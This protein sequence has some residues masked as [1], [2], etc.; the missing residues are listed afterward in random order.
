MLAVLKL[1]I[2]DN[3]LITTEKDY[4][5]PVYISFVMGCFSLHGKTAL[6][7]GPDYVG[8]YGLDGFIKT[9]KENRV[10]E[11]YI[12]T[13]KSYKSLLHDL[14]RVVLIE[15]PEVKI[16][17]V[18][19]DRLLNSREYK[20]ARTIYDTLKEDKSSILYHLDKLDEY[21]R[22]SNRFKAIPSELKVVNESI[23]KFSKED[24]TCERKI[25]L[26]DLEYLNLID[27]VALDGDRLILNIKPL[28]IYTSEPLGRFVGYSTFQDNKYIRK[29]TEY[30]YKG[31]HFGMVGTQIAIHPDF[32][33]EF[34][35]TLDHQ[36]DDLFKVN[37]W[38]NVGYL[39]FGKGRLCGGEFNDVI[40][41][42]NEHGLDYY[43]LCLKQYITTANLRDYAGMKVWWYPIYN[44]AGELVYCAGLD[45]MR[46]TLLNSNID[47]QSKEEIRDMS[48]ADFQ[49]W[50][51]RH[52]V[53][54]TDLRLHHM[55]T[56]I[57]THSKNE[58]T[59]LKWCQEHDEQLYNEIKE[60]ANI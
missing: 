6:G 24:K 51:L 37:N 21:K 10:T 29:A 43:F 22:F 4:M 11:L 25:T 3:F 2:G 44:E 33:P 55:S 52:G 38:S 30:I 1:K 31:C 47:S 35:D 15:C 59:F 9:I 36:W 7:V 32:K 54:F 40:A 49:E 56:D 34:I 19:M 5:M 8:T 12:L 50:R 20:L 18:K 53:L 26:Q 13:H 41:H 48:I 27:K 57:G 42:T 16:N 28:P 45:I 17:V 60:G 58:D 39:H 23:K 46:D 14:V